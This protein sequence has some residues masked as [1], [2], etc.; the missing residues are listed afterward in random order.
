MSD[1]S[2]IQMKEEKWVKNWNTKKLPLFF[3]C[4]SSS[5]SCSLFFFSFGCY[6]K[7]ITTGSLVSTGSMFQSGCVTHDDGKLSAFFFRGYRGREEDSTWKNKSPWL[8]FLSFFEWPERTHVRPNGSF[9]FP[10]W[11]RKTT[12]KRRS[13]GGTITTIARMSEGDIAL[14]L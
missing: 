4:I 13:E 14:S 10:L 3:R 11:L 7:I 1:V 5:L 12:G 2:I 9:R 8:F 6:L